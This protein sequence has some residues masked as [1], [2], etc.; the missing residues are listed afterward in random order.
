MN[1]YIIKKISSLISFLFLLLSYSQTIIPGLSLKNNKL[2]NEVLMNL[3][4]ISLPIYKYCFNSNI[5]TTGNYIKTNKIDIVVMNHIN[6]L[7]FIPF[8]STIR[9][10][11]KRNIYFIAKKQIID[12]PIFGDYFT[13]DNTLRLERSFDK[14]KENIIKF[15]EKIDNGVIY[16]YPEGTRFNTK[17][18][19]KAQE[20]SEKNNLH[21]FNNTLYPKM[22]GLYTLTNI[23]HEN[24]KMGNIIS[25]TG[26][27]ENFIKKNAYIKSLLTKRLGDT[28]TM[29]YT[30]KTPYIKDYEE[31][32]K[33]FLNIWH[34][35]NMNIE[36]YTNF[37]YKEVEP[38]VN[39]SIYI[40][41]LFVLFLFFYL[42]KKT[43]GIYII[44]GLI[45]SF[46]FK[47]NLLRH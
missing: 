18:F 13:G 8:A 12:I 3:I 16:I 41:S 17:K 19:K 15:V 46:I 39:T 42:I 4:D 31:F 24:N 21:K 11:D 45:L 23:L 25:I 10:Y 2:L 5:Y 28:Y 38:K 22:K 40:L 32:K 7:D 30:Y 37:E 1:K 27:V 14:D 9:Q 36:N 33:W 26:V 35:K 20:Y 43:K 34:I 47:K 6:T 44:S 29:I